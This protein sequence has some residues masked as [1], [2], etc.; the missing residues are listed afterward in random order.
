M[1]SSILV[2]NAYR[3]TLGFEL[4]AVH[5]HIPLESVIRGEVS[6][7]GVRPI[8]E[9]KSAHA[10][11]KEYIQAENYKAAAEWVLDFLEDLWPLGSLLKDLGVVA[12]RCSYCSG[13]LNQHTLVM[14]VNRQRPGFPYQPGSSCI[15]ESSLERFGSEV[16]V[17]MIFKLIS[18][19]AVS[20]DREEKLIARTAL[21][22]L[23][24]ADSQLN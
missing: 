9:W 22:A 21:E 13:G 20:D 23:Y 6:S 12:Y 15:V 17:V 1:A 16:R 8:L 10:G 19:A 18:E 7:I 2:F 24:Q 5:D 4:F 11:A 14:P 3:E